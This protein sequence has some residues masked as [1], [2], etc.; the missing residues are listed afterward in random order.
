MNTRTRIMLPT[1]GLVAAAVGGL[2][3]V[4]VA[5]STRIKHEAVSVAVTSSIHESEEA[6][7]LTAERALSH[8]AL[9]A[10]DPEVV[11][12]FARAHEGDMTVADDPVVAEARER[13]RG[14]FAER[15]ASYRRLTGERR[16][17]LHFH[18]PTGRSLLR[19]WDA[20]QSESDDL[21]R[22]RQSVLDVNSG[23]R[24][25]VAGIEVGR[26][27]LAIRGV[28][29]VTDAEGR[30]LGSVEMVADFG[31]LVHADEGTQMAAYL[32]AEEL[33][34]ATQ[35]A[36]ASR[37]PRVGEGFVQVAATAPEVLE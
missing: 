18:L 10:S 31:P 36:D 15:G 24:S 19:T 2:W 29:P 20:T 5:G 28:V 8:A 23:V 34:T 14:L 33:R 30:R 3:A 4:A 9:F 32:N 1:L 12:A 13:L 16:Y 25:T 11:A 7:E 6:V 35:L 22:F 17:G 37:H 21:S 27:G 26:A